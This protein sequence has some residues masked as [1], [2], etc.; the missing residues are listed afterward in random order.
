MRP[1]WRELWVEA[2]EK[3]EVSSSFGGAEAWQ[4]GMAMR[5]V[6]QAR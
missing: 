5:E 2:A 1:E 3:E 6:V 4:L